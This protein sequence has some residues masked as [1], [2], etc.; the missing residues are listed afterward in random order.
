MKT[1][2]FFLYMKTFQLTNTAT[3]NVDK[4]NVCFSD[5]KGIK[6][7]KMCKFTKKQM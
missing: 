6:T 4:Y 3:T 7:K 1:L 5:K 2:S